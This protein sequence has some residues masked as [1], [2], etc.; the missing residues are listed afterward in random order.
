MLIAV[1]GPTGFIGSQLVPALERD[2]HVVRRIVRSRPSAGDVQW[3]PDE[4]RIDAAALAGVEAVIHLAGENIGQRWTDAAKRR[5]RE[6]RVVGTHLLAS[7]LAS[8]PRAPRIFISAS[9]IGIY[10]ADRDDEVLDESSE[11]GDDFLS[12]LGVEWEAATEP[13]AAAGIRVVR[14]RFGVVLDP[15]GGMLGRILPVF[16]LGLGGRLGDGKSWMSWVSLT[17]LIEVM[18]F[19]LRV[20]ALS[21][22][23]NVTAPHPV[24]NAEFTATLGLVL[25]RPAIAVVPA[26]ALRTVYGEMA[27]ATILAS[28]RVLPAK[29]TAAGF[30]FEHPKLEAAL[31]AELKN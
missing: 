7:T 13:A 14:T 23:V 18:R 12:D 21:G 25:R 20:P 5:I 3:S 11:P 17:D 31:R 24:R 6:S 15:A 4:R 28:Q 1:S 29:L 26:F 2:E 19:L 27:D 22:A 10:G 8:L 16:R 9:A 30:R